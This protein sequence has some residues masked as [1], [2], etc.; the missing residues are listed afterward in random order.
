MDSPLSIAIITIGATLTTAGL[1]WLA[2]WRTQLSAIGRQHHLREKADDRAQWT[3]HLDE[4][5][6]AAVMYAH[7]VNL[8]RA[9]WIE[10]PLL[11]RFRTRRRIALDLDQVL[12]P[13]LGRL[14]LA[15]IRTTSWRDAAPRVV[16]QAETLGE[17][18]GT[19][20]TAAAAGRE[21]F[22]EA[23]RRYEEALAG[24]REQVDARP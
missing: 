23:A 4:T 12:T 8:I 20:F 11:D 1:G 3:R 9:G 19:L 6:A 5:L 24:F 10:D 15:L 13:P 2:A 7:A 18:A 21:A 22:E 16:E 17:T 14:T